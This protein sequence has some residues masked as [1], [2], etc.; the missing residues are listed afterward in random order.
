M[1]AKA[2]RNVHYQC[3]GSFRCFDIA[4]ARAMPLVGLVNGRCRALQ[5]SLS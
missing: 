3:C 5:P 4:M 2:Q 1:A